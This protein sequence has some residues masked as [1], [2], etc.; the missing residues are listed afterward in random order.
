MERVSGSHTRC[1]LSES[2][3]CAN[4]TSSGTWRWNTGEPNNFKQEKCGEMIKNG[5]YN[6]IKCQAHTYDDNP[7]YICEKYFS[8][9]MIMPKLCYPN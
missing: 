9:F 5:K 4:E 7:G 6:N 2:I 3:A 8:V 1:W